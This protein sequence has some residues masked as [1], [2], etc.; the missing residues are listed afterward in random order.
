MEKSRQLN[1]ERG[2]VCDVEARQSHVTDSLVRDRMALYSVPGMSIAVVNE[3]KIDWSAGYGVMAGDGMAAVSDSTL[4]QCCSTSKMVAGLLTMRLVSLGILDL[5]EDINSVLEAWKLRFADGIPAKVTLRQVL[6]HTGGINVHG[7][8][9]YPMGSP[10][11]SLNEV[12]DGLP[13]AI[14]APVRVTSEIGATFR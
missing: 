2:L 3:G 8:P 9:G 7:A 13:P 10:F 11:P 6:S 14:T 1:V 4:F 5:D 12:L